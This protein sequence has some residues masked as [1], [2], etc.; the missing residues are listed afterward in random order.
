M[1][2]RGTDHAEFIGVHTELPVEFQACL[3]SR[4]NV[5]GLGECRWAGA[6]ESL[7]INLKIGKFIP[8]R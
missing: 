4:A 2:V 1:V 5:I 6:G 3:E 7:F 8:W